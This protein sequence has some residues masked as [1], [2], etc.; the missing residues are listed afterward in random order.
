MG[1][2]CA[3][4]V[5]FFEWTPKT[6]QC[7]SYNNG[8]QRL[9]LSRSDGS[10]EIWSVKDGWYQEDV[11]P[12]MEDRSVEDLVWQ[13]ERLFYAG[14]QGNI[15]ELDL[16]RLQ[17]KASSPSNAGPVWCLTSNTAQTRLAAGTEEGCVVL[18]NT[19]NGEL[20][21]YSR[22]DSQGSRILCLAWHPTEDIIVT[23]GIDNIRLWSVSSGRALQRLSVAR[24]VK[25][26]ET[27]V[28]C[29][30]FL[31]DM[32]IV[33]GDSRGKTSFWNGKQGTVI[34]SIQSHK[35]D[36]YCLA[37]DQSES[38]IVSSG[39]DSSVVQFNYVTSHENSDW[40]DW[41]GTFVHNQ[42]THDVRAVE[43]IDKTIVTGG[44]DT[45]LIQFSLKAK[46]YEGSKRK[47]TSENKWKHIA[48]VPQK[49]LVKVARNV[50][51]IMLQY[52]HHLEVWRLG[53]T[54]KTGANG[55][56]LPLRSNPIKLIQLKTKGGAPMYS[57][58]ISP[59]ASALAYSDCDTTRVYSIQLDNLTSIQPSVSM[60]RIPL[61]ADRPPDGA[62]C[63]CFTSDSQRIVTVSSSS[64]I[65]V[66]AVQSDKVEELHTFPSHSA[67]YHLLS[68]SPDDHYAAAAD[69]LCNVHIYD[70]QKL[71]Y[72]CNV[73]R[74]SCQVSALSFSPDSTQIA[75]AYTNQQ[76]FE[77]DI[78]N[79]EYSLW[80]KKYSQKFGKVWLRRKSKISK[81]S[82]NPSNPNH[83]VL[84]DEQMFCILDKT[85]PFPSH[86]YSWQ[87]LCTPTLD[88]SSAFHIC[89]NYK[90]LMH[91]E[92]LPDNW[93][94]AVE[95][96][97]LELFST[98]PD[99]LKRKK[100][101][102]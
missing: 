37:V 14:L 77:Y 65:H 59:D 67:S 94:I 17:A 38:T 39:I 85:Q 42:H 41:I 3:H 9:A 92:V 56:I 100:F 63:M 102:T 7:M 73:P 68:I 19:E 54:D 15:C 88:N 74:Y 81:I 26:K 23:G 72:L 33:S 16:V 57:S 20:E 53:F 35:A 47:Q 55:E 25:N 86:I 78:M 64:C 5:R 71:Q 50:N 48:P 24:Q 82:Y 93:L 6:I 43:I 76:I 40:K 13:G 95:R 51:I 21:Y 90:F 45:N 32:T 89:T 1:E 101:G 91:L 2:F 30:A 75:M 27:V 62:H 80:S 87:E 66:C 18:L 69:H 34:K 61:S 12:G 58:D 84:H 96:P 46:G 52:P 44:V 36:V 31:S 98:L 83:L 22:F 11:I 4:H 99:A 70:L 60:K 29:V 49:S 79:R 28:W 10:I 97:P 8:S